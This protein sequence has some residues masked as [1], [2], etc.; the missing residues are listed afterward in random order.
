[1][2]AKRVLD[3]ARKGLYRAYVPETGNLS[4]VRGRIDVQE[5]A[6]LIRG[7]Y[8]KVCCEFDNHTS[9]LE[10]NQILLWT[11]S[12]IS[13]LNLKRDEVRNQVRTARRVL[14]GA[15]SLSPMKANDCVDRIYNRLNTDYEPLHSI[16]RFFLEN[17]GPGINHGSHQNIPFTVNMP[18]LFEQF[19][20]KW[21]L[22][23]LPP[24]LKL[25]AQHH[26][27]L[28]KDGRLSFNIDLVLFD[29]HSEKSVAVLDTKYKRTSFPS[30]SDIQQI[31]A[32]AVEMRTTKAILIYPIETISPVDLMVGDINVRSLYF[33][34]NTDLDQSGKALLD[35]LDSMLD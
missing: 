22:Q 1:M 9:D 4:F 27:Q 8:A 6:K 14:V 30:Q 11:L 23:N 32:Y 31:V 20:A 18:V 33:D 7:G 16:C 26:V 5:T 15:T 12:L 25:K 17:C 19:V 29:I 21:L 24:S 28:D 2:L 10:E 13:R 35:N 34:L 3:R